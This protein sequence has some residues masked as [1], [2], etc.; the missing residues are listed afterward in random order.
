MIADSLGFADF[1]GLCESA[2]YKELDIPI[3]IVD[4][5][6][7]KDRSS[8]FLDT[9]LWGKMLT[10]KVSSGTCRI[11]RMLDFLYDDSEI[12]PFENDSAFMVNKSFASLYRVKRLPAILLVTA[13]DVNFI[14]YYKDDQD[15]SYITSSG[16]CASWNYFL[17]KN[18]DFFALDYL[19][20]KGLTIYQN[21]NKYFSW[22][23]LCK[24]YFNRAKSSLESDLNATILAIH[25]KTSYSLTKE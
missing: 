22:C 15:N 2:I 8:C 17:E 11:P 5:P 24:V 13:Q 7:Q 19:R 23:Q 1:S 4:Q 6:R 16:A 18:A 21:Y 10:S 3:F 12:I 9:L 14:K 25:Q 20:N